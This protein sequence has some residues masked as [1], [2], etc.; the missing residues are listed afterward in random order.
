MRRYKITIHEKIASQEM[1][2]VQIYSSFKYI[3]RHI[4]N[5]KLNKNNV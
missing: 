3:A 5:L 2:S 4:I 1:R